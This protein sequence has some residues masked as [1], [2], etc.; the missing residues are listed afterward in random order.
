MLHELRTYTFHP[1]KLPVYL[2]LAEEVG[3]PTRGNNYGV[4]RGYWTPE[5]GRLNQIWHLWEY[6][7]YEQ[8]THL[9][10]EL[11]KN[12]DWTGKYIPNLLPLLQTQEIRFLNPALPLTAPEGE[13]NVYELRIYRARAGMSQTWLKQFKEIMPVR[14]KYSKNV[15]LWWGEAPQPHEVAHMWAYR[16]A[17]D[18]FATRAKVAADPAWQGFLAEAGGCLEDMQSIFLLPTNY[19]PMK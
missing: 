6:E 19:S 4:N 14:E 13:G 18:R 2:K 5:F 3:R 11:Q 10:A 7:S 12:P 16:D 1:G 8:R 9:R 17:N 15:G